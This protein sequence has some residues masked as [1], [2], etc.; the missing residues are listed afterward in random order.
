MNVAFMLKPYSVY[1]SDDVIENVKTYMQRNYQKDL[2]QDYIASLFYM[3]RSYLSSQFRKKTGE[4]FVDYLN[5]VRLEHAEELLQKPGQKMYQ[6]AKAVGYDNEKY[7]FRIF[8]KRTGMTPDQ[9]RKQ[10]S[11]KN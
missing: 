4:K 9:Y 6:V 5:D 8:R 3:N 7:F 2:T 11:G 1:N 10:L